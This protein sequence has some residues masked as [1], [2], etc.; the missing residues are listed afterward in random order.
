MTSV[1][2]A[3][4]RRSFYEADVLFRQF[5][6]LYKERGF[7]DHDP[8]VLEVSLK[9]AGSYA[10]MGL[11]DLS[12]LGY[13]FVVAQARHRI[14]MLLEAQSSPP[15]AAAHAP[16][17][18]GQVLP[19]AAKPTGVW[20]SFIGRLGVSVDS[21]EEATL[22]APKAS[23]DDAH[24]LLGMSLQGLGALLIHR[25]RATEA[26]EA[27]RAAVEVCKGLS[28]PNHPQVPVLLT[29]LS[30]AYV[31]VGRYTEAVD[32]AREAVEVSEASTGENEVLLKA[33]LA[34]IL[35]GAGDHRE[36]ERVFHEAEVISRLV[37]AVWCG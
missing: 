19:P 11:L 9:L 30:D 27:F 34:T 25:G 28:G 35:W 20:Q 17:Q 29:Y 37:R 33:N 21:T 1:L 24:A 31:S 7:A 8:V 5:L 23:L 15:P 18:A 26:A 22:P 14:A 32:A 36:A 6:K 16:A 12:E 4:V 10:E 3:R 13:R 2:I